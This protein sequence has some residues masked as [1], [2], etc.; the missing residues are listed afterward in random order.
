MAK[1]LQKDHKFKIL[2]YD[3]ASECIG[4]AGK[5]DS[6]GWKILEETMGVNILTVFSCCYKM[7][8]RNST[9]DVLAKLLKPE[10]RGM[11]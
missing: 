11:D 6:G 2:L 4:L 10:N 7:F 8:S 1:P 3:E 9:Q 5:V